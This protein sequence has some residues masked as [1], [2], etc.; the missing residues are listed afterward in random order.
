MAGLLGADVHTQIVRAVDGVSLA[1][2]EGEV[3]GLVGESGC[4][5][6]TIGRIVAGILP[7]SEGAVRYRGRPHPGPGRRVGLRQVDHRPA[8]ARRRDPRR[9]RGAL[10]R[11]ADAGARVAGMAAPARP[12]ADGAPG[13]A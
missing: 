6:S 8:G 5:K 7:P 2:G 10:R 11:G 9:G 4:G 13:S 3:L 12:A 1:V